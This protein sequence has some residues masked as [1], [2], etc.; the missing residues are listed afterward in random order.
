MY[1]FILDEY[2]WH[3]RRNLVLLRSITRKNDPDIQSKCCNF[4]N[5]KIPQWAKDVG[6]T[7]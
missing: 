6:I 1:N 5:I 4:D 3:R 7:L 2:N